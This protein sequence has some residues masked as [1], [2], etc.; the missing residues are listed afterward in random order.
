MVACGA[1][2]TPATEGEKLRRRRI[3]PEQ[4]KEMWENGS[5]TSHALLLLSSE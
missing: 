4:G 1:S 3:I 5:S 2:V